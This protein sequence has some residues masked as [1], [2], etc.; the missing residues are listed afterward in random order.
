MFGKGFI[1]ENFQSKLGYWF[2]NDA[3][4]QTAVTHSSYANE[5]KTESNERLEFL[6]DSVLSIIVSDYIFA[7]LPKVDEGVLT[8]IRA[9]LVC[10]QSLAELAKKISIDA[11]IQLGKGE[12][13]AGGR[14]RASILSDAF[15]AVLAAIYLDGGMETARKWLL[16]LMHDAIIQV[17]HGDGYRDYKTMLQEAVQRGNKGKVTY[18]TVKESGPDH[19]KYF[20]VEV[21]IDERVVN[22]GTGASKKEA[23]Q[24]A[25]QAVLENMDKQHG[26]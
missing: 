9:S 23:E 19:N 10:E 20:E 21:M 2:K 18:R 16:D 14:N 8:K 4:L 25:A 3:L 13:M 7:K 11:Y 6:G 26:E 24:K 5:K 12:E 1:M 22:G 17:L 15:E